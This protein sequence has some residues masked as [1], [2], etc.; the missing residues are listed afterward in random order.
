MPKFLSAHVATFLL[1]SLVTLLLVYFKVE[2]S[3]L[4]RIVAVL[5]FVLLIFLNKFLNPNKQQKLSSI[6]SQL[7]LFLGT[8]FIQLIVIST[9]GLKSPFLVMIHLFTLGVSFLIN[10]PSALI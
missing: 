8:L 5:L 9:G 6:T 2:I 3:W 7:F 1:A 4:Q 10:L